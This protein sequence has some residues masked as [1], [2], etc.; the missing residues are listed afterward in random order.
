MASDVFGF[1]FSIVK[2]Y[3]IGL[4]YHKV[5]KKVRKMSLHELEL[6]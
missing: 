6:C 2:S 3:V 1:R 5:K 4:Y